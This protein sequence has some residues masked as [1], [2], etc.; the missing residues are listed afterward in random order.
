[1]I[2]NITVEDITNNSINFVINK[3][4]HSPRKGAYTIVRGF[5][6]KEGDWFSSEDLVDLSRL[7]EMLRAKGAYIFP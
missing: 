5:S 1:M 3:P 2:D 4:G 6:F 7:W